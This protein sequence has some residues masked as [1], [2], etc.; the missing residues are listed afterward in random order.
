MVWQ[1]VPTVCPSKRRETARRESYLISVLSWSP[2]LRWRNYKLE[3]QVAVVTD[4]TGV[5]SSAMARAAAGERD[6]PGFFVGGQTRALLL[7][8]DGTLTAR[9]Q[10]IIDH[11]PARLRSWSAR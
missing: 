3:G 11:T 7:N 5:L 8:E 10:T 6:P 1:S 2:C 4:G 9:G